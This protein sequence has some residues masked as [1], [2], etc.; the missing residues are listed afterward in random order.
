MSSACSRLQFC[1]SRSRGGHNRCQSCRYIF[2][3][4]VVAQSKAVAAALA[5]AAAAD[6]AAA[7]AAAAAAVAAA[8]AAAATAA[9]AASA[10][11]CFYL[12]F[13]AAYHHISDCLLM[14]HCS[15]AYRKTI[16]LLHSILQ[17]TYRITTARS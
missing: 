4:G 13:T 2:Y 9:A 11:C 3:Y 16:Q 6:A 10:C 8:V 1:S 5:A 17:C 7:P 15:T 12:C 14:Q